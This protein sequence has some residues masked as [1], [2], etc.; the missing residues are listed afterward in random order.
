MA[1]A[2]SCAPSGP[3]DRQIE[4]E[5]VK[6]LSDESKYFRFMSA[7]RELNDGVLNRFTPIDYDRWFAKT[8]RKRKSGS[9]VL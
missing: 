5:F 9:R 3:K 6:T 1:R 8:R 2:W 4:K 7:L